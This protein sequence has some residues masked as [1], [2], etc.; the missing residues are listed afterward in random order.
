VL[1]NEVT[2]DF[3]VG[4]AFG[5]HPENVRH[6]NA[7]SSD[8]WSPAAFVRF[9]RDAFEQLHTW[10]H[11]SPTYWN[12]LSLRDGLSAGFPSCFVVI[13]VFGRSR[14]TWPA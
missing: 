14:P 5:E 6:A 9:K 2:K 11:A 4:H 10:H 12:Q 13:G 8:A 7:Q 1:P 3:V